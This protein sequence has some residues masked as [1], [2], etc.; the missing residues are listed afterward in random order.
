MKEIKY[1]KESIIELQS[2]AEIEKKDLLD[3]I[4][5]M[6][7]NAEVQKKKTQPMEIPNGAENSITRIRELLA[8]AW[9]EDSKNS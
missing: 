2:K 5:M 4:E 6:W 3:S 9:F 8:C 7:L 1:V